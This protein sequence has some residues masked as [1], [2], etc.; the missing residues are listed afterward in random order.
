MHVRAGHNDTLLY[1]L[2]RGYAED[3]FKV[4][5]CIEPLAP[6][7]QVVAVK[8]KRVVDIGITPFQDFNAEFLLKPAPDFFVNSLGNAEDV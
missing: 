1:G 8:M 5:L 4:A 2:A 6:G 3:V 7:V